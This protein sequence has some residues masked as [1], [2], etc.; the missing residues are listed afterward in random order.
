MFFKNMLVLVLTFW[1]K[2]FYKKIIK[3]NYSWSDVSSKVLS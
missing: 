3:L 2:T 1:T